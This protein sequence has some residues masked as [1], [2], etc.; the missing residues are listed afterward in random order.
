MTNTISKDVLTAA[1]P[2]IAMF[3]L[4]QINEIAALIGSILGI[5]FLLWRWRREAMGKG[6]R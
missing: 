1:T 6:K 5:A 2:T 4:G 3:S